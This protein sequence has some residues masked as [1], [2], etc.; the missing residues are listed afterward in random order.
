MFTY[1]HCVCIHIKGKDRPGEAWVGEG[2]NVQRTAGH[3]GFQWISDI[4]KGMSNVNQCSKFNRA[5]NLRQLGLEV[6]TRHVTRFVN[7]YDRLRTDDIE[8]GK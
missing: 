5:V 3:E 2:S 6:K 8:G 1:L 4:F 7:T